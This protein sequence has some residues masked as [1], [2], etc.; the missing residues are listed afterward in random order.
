MAITVTETTDLQ[1][2]TEMTRGNE[3]ASRT[4]S[5]PSAE[6]EMLPSVMAA[7]S[8]LAAS[9]LGGYSTVF[10]PT[11]WRD[12][13]VAEDEYTITSAKVELVTKTTTTLTSLETEG[14]VFSVYETDS[15]DPQHSTVRAGEILD[16]AW[17]F[18]AGED[19]LDIPDAYGN[20]VVD[21]GGASGYSVSNI[22]ND[23]FGRRGKITCGNED[24]TVN[25][26]WF[27]GDKLYKTADTEDGSLIIHVQ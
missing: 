6:G 25:I 20:G 12:E 7:G 24:A 11:S 14:K 21:F 15:A 13:D 10:Q 19:Y 23:G 1:I 9:L 4:F 22:E 26:S 18:Q 16:V 17:G 5:F 27:L 8:D 2:T 3:S